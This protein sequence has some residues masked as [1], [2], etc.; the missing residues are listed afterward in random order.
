MS[1]REVLWDKLFAYDVARP[2]REKRKCACGHLSCRTAKKIKCVCSCHA[3]FHGV[4]NRRGMQ[5]LD[6][7]LGIEREA[8][9]LHD[10]A[11]DLELS[12]RTEQ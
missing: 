4:E 9:R 5:P 8:P 6:K 7:T 10:L 3:Q 12:G 2:K 1:E 11:L